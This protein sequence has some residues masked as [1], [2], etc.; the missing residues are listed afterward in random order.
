MDMYDIASNQL[1]FSDA[2]RQV[3]DVARQFERMEGA[4][5]LSEKPGQTGASPLFLASSNRENAFSE[6]GGTTLF[7]TALLWALGG[8]AAV[9]PDDHCDEWHV[10]ATQLIAALPARVKALAGRY[11]ATQTVDVTGNVHEVIAQ[12]FENPPEVDVEVRLLP[13]GVMPEP[14][15]RV[16][17]DGSTPLP[18]PAGWPLRFRGAAGLYL[19]EMQ[20]QLPEPWFR[21]KLLDVHPPACMSSVEVLP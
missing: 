12:R 8:A 5:R 1:W 18:V 15:A 17:F 19:I 6:I 10:G 2:C 20:R 3:P 21:K 16:S 13:L 4:L 7:S 11:G 9:G 14:D